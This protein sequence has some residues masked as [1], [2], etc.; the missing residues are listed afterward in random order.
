MY[1]LPKNRG[2][3][4]PTQ[5]WQVSSDRS[6]LWA[7]PFQTGVVKVHEILLGLHHWIGLVE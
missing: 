5:N 7:P 6:D 2:A 1:P 4:V 3:Y